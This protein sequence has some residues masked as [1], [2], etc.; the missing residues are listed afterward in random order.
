MADRR[1]HIRAGGRVPT[2]VGGRSCGFP[3]RTF[4]RG[5]LGRVDTMRSLTS[6]AAP[7]DGA[8]A[9]RG[10]TLVPDA[11]AGPPAPAGAKPCPARD[12]IPR[13]R[14]QRHRRHP[15]KDFTGPRGAGVA[16]MTHAATARITPTA[17]PPTRPGPGR[18]CLRS[19][20]DRSLG[21]AERGSLVVRNG[22]EPPRAGY[23]NEPFRRR[24]SG[25]TLGHG[26]AGRASRHRRG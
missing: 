25:R 21:S 11:P 12:Y 24:R 2:G 14:L 9:A 22:Q 23:H 20:S 19:A 10:A 5:P 17:P 13:R 16:L 15:G 8:P 3:P 1:G 6:L 18:R 7:F 4:G 26:G